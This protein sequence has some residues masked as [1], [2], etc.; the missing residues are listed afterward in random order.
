MLRWIVQTVR[1]AEE[2]WVEYIKRATHAAENLAVQHKSIDWVQLQRRRQWLF[3]GKVAS[4]DD[5]RWST[6]L[7]KWRPWFRVLPGRSV[8]R[9]RKRW[10][11]NIQHLAGGD[12]VQVAQ[13]HNLW[14]ALSQG[15]VELDF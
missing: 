2:D 10:D 3:A 1:L 5:R 4:A 12:W 8:G 7:L 14:Q 15:Y 9:P 11:D 6:P 13:D